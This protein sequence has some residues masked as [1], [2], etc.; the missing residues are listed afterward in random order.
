MRRRTTHWLIPLI[1]IVQMTAIPGHAQVTNKPGSATQVPAPTG[2]VAVT[3]PGYIASGQ[4]LLVNYERERDAMGRITDTIVFASAG[5]VDV[6]QTTRYVD[7][8]G[9][10]LQTVIQ[11]ATPGSNPS[12]VVTPL[13]YDQFGREIYKYLPYVASAGNTNDGN[14][15]QDPFTDQANFYKNVYPSQQ[16]AYTGE[17]VYYSQTNFEASPLN[18]PL[19]ALSAGNSWAGS[20][21]GVSQEYLVN[22]SAD[23]VQIWDISNDTLTYLDNDLT[24]NI[25]TASGYYSAGQLYKNVTIDEQGHAVVE[26]TDMDGL[27]ILKKVQSS[28][29]PSDF[30]GYSGWLATYYI[31]DNLNQL[32]FVLP[33]KAVNIAYNNNWN[34]SADTTTINE[35]T[36]RYEYDYRQRMTAK[37]L[38]GADWIYMIYDSRN[39]LVF[40]Q[41][42]NM[43]SQNQWMTT[44]YDGLNRSTTSGMIT[45]AGTPNQLQQYVTANTVSNAA[46]TITV[47]GT[48]PS[49]PQTLDLTGTENGDD[50]A[51]NTIILDNGFSTPDTVNFT[52][53]IVTGGSG[54]GAPFSNTVAVVDNPIPTGVNLIALTMTFYDDYSNT[55]DKLYSATY[56]SRLDAGTN[57]HVEAVPTTTMQQAILTIGQVTGTKVRVIENP[58]DLTQGN[59]LE[60]ATFFDDRLRVAQTQSDNYK[61]GQ[62]TI[63]NLYNFT[64]KVLTTYVAHGNPQANFNNNIRVKTNMN[65]DA[66]NRALQVYTSVNDTGQRLIS[67]LNYDQMSHVMQKQLGQLPD[68]SFLET[69]DLTYNIRG[70]LKGINKDYAN[71]VN[72]NGD[73]NRW[74]GMELSYDWGFGTNYLNGNISGN[75]WRSRG[76]G[77]QRAYGFGY[78]EANRFLYADFNQ[79]SGSGWD[80]SAGVDFSAV[81]GNGTDPSTAYDQNGNILFMQQEAWQLGG[82]HLIDSLKYTYYNNSNKLKNVIDGD[83][84]PATTLGDFRTSSLSPYANSKTTAAIDYTYDGNG[85]LLTDLNKDIG[86]QTTNGIIYNYLNQPWQIN[87]RSATGT[88]GTITYIYDAAGTKLKKTTIDSTGNLET[89]TTYIGLFQYQAT[90]PLTGTG[91]GNL[92]DTLQ[93]VAH[94]E[95]RVRAENDTADGATFGSFKFDYFLRDHLGNTRMVLTDEQQTDMYPAATM[96]VGDSATENLY[97]MNLD[98]TRVSLPPG[99]PTDTTTNPNNYVAEV[100]GST[101]EPVIG[102]GIVLKVMA[103]DQFS[104]RVS[105]WYQLNGTTPGT[106]TNP[107]T[108]VL[109]HMIAGMAA[110]P[111]PENPGLAVLQS[112]TPI[113]SS[114]V[115]NFLQDTGTSIVDSRPHAFLNWVLLDNQFN[116]VAASSGFSQVGNSGQLN[117]ITLANLPI[118]SSGYLY[119][120]VSNETPN[121][122]VYFDNLQLTHVRGPLLE[123]DHYYP[124][125]L[126][127]AGISDKAVKTAYTQ[128]KYRYTGKELQNQEFT[129]GSGLEDYDFGARR[130]DHQVGRWQGIDAL[131]ESSTNT[132]PYNYVFNN[133]G[134]LIDPDGMSVVYDWNT[135]NYVETNQLGETYNVSADYAFSAASVSDHEFDLTALW[136][137][138]VNADRI[139]KEHDYNCSMC[140]LKAMSSNL[141]TLYNLAESLFALS[142]NLADVLKPIIAMGKA[143]AL[144]KV[145]PTV[146]GKK[147]GSKKWEESYNNND[148]SRNTNIPG[149]VANAPGV[150]A[151]TTGINLFAV[152]IAGGYHTLL[153]GYF[154]AGVPIDLS[155]FPNTVIPWTYYLYIDDHGVRV[156]SPGDLE[157]LLRQYYD[158]AA[159]WYNGHKKLDGKSVS[160][161]GDK[162]MGGQVYQL[163]Q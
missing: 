93:F 76:D 87:F 109:A 62:D 95:G 32:R 16:P 162:D 90:A 9:R 140:C 14:F 45:Y 77:Q 42:A 131:T 145:D 133:P 75:K 54:S 112:N 134:K 121:V 20:G 158:G 43:R 47:S 88:K 61:G 66:D 24:T 69:Q 48:S 163:S 37:K 21:V 50:Q 117:V 148:N 92:I 155:G 52:A 157:S 141:A 132:S 143:T 139:S 56:A 94:A 123:E 125:G 119:I 8:L 115:F 111:N 146:N 103:G 38:P 1:L 124:F 19:Q 31:Y 55:P 59:W 11:Q 34:L 17:Q 58:S 102:P 144:M 2:T 98:S 79:Y 6:R 130:Y 80:K 120:Y 64:G 67:Q 147:A 100:G 81:M 91:S 84:N 23:S 44:I 126:T 30:S 122:P 110:L 108:D 105:N 106:P 70:W 104:V 85:N 74:F 153:L 7:G 12:D 49:I 53:E 27:L 99:Y 129:D 71:N 96:E 35:L 114:N 28:T 25:P 41:D 128:N 151:N 137:L 68:S 150:T 13:V 26:Y 82:S 160:K 135:G 29:V 18:R 127:M 161:P 107:L 63:V 149:A 113:L 36:F 89:V 159:K 33:P 152:G 5:Y 51:L 154:A 10:P 97:Y 72:N 57:Q 118:T 60:T 4:S 138:A 86:S 142:G 65:L 83:N 3:P 116:Y 46:A 101:S 40:S 136:K 156:L 39:R 15:K 22:T 78:D 73:D